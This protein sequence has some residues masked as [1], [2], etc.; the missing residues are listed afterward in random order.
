MRFI[1]DET[2]RRASYQRRQAIQQMKKLLR[3]LAIPI[4]IT[5]SAVALSWAMISSRAELPRREV[6][7]PVPLVEVM[8]IEPATLR[9]NI[10]SQG[11]VQA[12]Q[13]IDLVSEVSGRVI[14]VAPEF[15]TGG[16]VAAGTLLLQID[17]INYEVAITE[18]QAAV[19]GAKLRLSEVKVVLMHAAIEEA[20]ASVRAAQA[21]LRAAR[22]NLHNTKIVVP[23]NAVIDSKRVDLGQFVTTGLPLMHLLSTDIAEVRLP[24]LASDISFIQTATSAQ[25]A[26][27]DV[28]FT[29]QRGN[30]ELQ[31]HG[32]I[33]RLEQR[34]DKKTRVFYL[35]AQVKN[36]YQNFEGSQPF[37]V[38]LF[39]DATIEGKE[40]QDAVRIPRS[41]LHEGNFVYLIENNR[42]KK[43]EVNV[44]R[45]EQDSLL[46]E[47]GLN[48]GDVLALSRLH[49]MVEGTLVAL[50]GS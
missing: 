20:E 41:A 5:A 45:R 15:V 7:T 17:P 14:W 37:S 42:L 16:N 21:R 40:I 9:V 24:V 36:P 35:V 39:V 25:E 8:T 47:E 32:Q 46:I 13:E 29:A 49:L 34:V 12:M 6:I 31:W 28:L 19:A 1:T 3:K 44:L 22:A 38:G 50:A 18:A 4:A 11:T 30:T 27:P 48:A 2:A 26:G 23:F 10:R 43:R 33:A